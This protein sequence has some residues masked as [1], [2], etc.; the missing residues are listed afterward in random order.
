MPKVYRSININSCTRTNIWRKLLCKTLTNDRARKC[1]NVEKISKN[2]LIIK[3]KNKL[4][5]KDT[6]TIYSCY[7]SLI[8]LKVF[9]YLT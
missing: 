4:S 2:L 1:R 7:S 9:N 6:K 8:L 5:P 3:I